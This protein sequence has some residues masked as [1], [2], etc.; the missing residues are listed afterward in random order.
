MFLNWEYF[1]MAGFK[2]VDD[3]SDDDIVIQNSPA[4]D[5]TNDTYNE[6]VGATEDGK[7]VVFKITAKDEKKRVAELMDFVSSRIIAAVNAGWKTD[8]ILKHTAK[9]LIELTHSLGLP[10][11]NNAESNAL[12]LWKKAKQAYMRDEILKHVTNLNAEMGIKTPAHIMNPEKPRFSTALFNAL[13]GD[14]ENATPALEFVYKAGRKEEKYRYDQAMGFQAISA[15]TLEIAKIKGAAKSKGRELTE[16]EH[17]DISV[18]KDKRVELWTKFFEGSKTA[19]ANARAKFPETVS[20]G[21][22]TTSG[23]FKSASTHD[24]ISFG[25]FLD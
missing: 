21:R 10:S 12:G 2:I 23:V 6:F 14:V 13:A 24:E 1:T 18:L 4:G 16:A 25:V 20:T 17:D 11:L 15:C 3:V 8:F 9:M 22:T 5:M 19:I 7:E